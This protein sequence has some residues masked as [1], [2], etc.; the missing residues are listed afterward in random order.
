MDKYIYISIPKTG[1]NSV[2][3]ILGNTRYNHIKAETI[4]KKIGDKEYQKKTSFC[5]I[6]NPVDLIKSW[7]YYHKYSPNVIRKDVKNFYP[8]TIDEWV[9]DMN[10]RTHWEQPKHRK[11]NPDWNIHESPLH[12]LSW[13]TNKNNKIIVDHVL[14]FDDFDKEIQK[15]LGVKPTQKNSSNKDTFTL[16]HTTESRIKQLFKIDIEFY[17]N[18]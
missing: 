18:M 13:I 10:C 12:Q 16:K 11:Y 3:E 4:L 5:F 1:T 15:L 9:L 14:S 6:R 2:H 17:Q 7:Y 8:A